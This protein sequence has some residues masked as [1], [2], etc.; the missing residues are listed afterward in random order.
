MIGR[1]ARR[2]RAAAGTQSGYALGE[3]TTSPAVSLHDDVLAVLGADER[4]WSETIAAR[5]AG[6]R[7]D[8]Y[9]GWDAN[10]LGDALRVRGVEPAQQW[11][12]TAEGT[13]ANRRGVTREQITAAL[14]ASGGPARSS[15]TASGQGG[16]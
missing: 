12:Q 6:L 1:R 11:G 2:L 8:F 10:T 4:A 9:K 14:G 15:G 3:Q 7:P 13:G 5:L 16:P